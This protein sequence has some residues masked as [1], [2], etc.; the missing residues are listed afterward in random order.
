[1][2]PQR[3][4]ADNPD[5]LSDDRRGLGSVQIRPVRLD[6]AAA[7]AAIYA[8]QVLHGTASFEL[9]PPDSTEM[10]ARIARVLNHGWPW[11]V[12]QDDRGAVLGYAYATQFRDRAAYRYVC[13]DSI[14]IHHDAHGRGL[15]SALLAALITACEA[16]GFRQMVGVIAGAAPASVALHAGQGFV[17]AG[18]MTAIGRKQGRWI[19]T[20]YMQRPLGEGASTPPPQEPD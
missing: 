4:R 8:H 18:R 13:E 7:I 10:A 20:L 2:A 9:A 19:D 5:R 11:L 15:G 6:D 17:E 16:A 12:A 3:Q 1:M 14:Y